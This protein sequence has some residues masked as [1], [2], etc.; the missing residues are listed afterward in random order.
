MKCT[1]AVCTTQSNAYVEHY[2][3]DALVTVYNALG[4]SPESVSGKLTQTMSGM[5][6]KVGNSALGLLGTTSGAQ[7]RSVTDGFKTAN[8]YRIADVYGSPAAA[9]LT[10]LLGQVNTIAACETSITPYKP[11]FVSSTNPLVWNS[12]VIDAISS[13]KTSWG[14]GTIGERS[15]GQSSPDN[16]WGTVN[17]RVGVVLNHDHLKVASVIAYRAMDIVFNGTFGIFNQT[18]GGETLRWYQPSHKI[19]EKSTEEGKWQMLYPRYES[20]CHVLADKSTM[21]PSGLDFE[22]WSDR[23]SNDGSYA[24]HYWRRYECCKRPSGYS[25]LFKTTW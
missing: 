6:G 17:P 21:K 16:S 15:D 4:K 2:S 3:P 8:H 11:Y 1:L 19:S 20:S 25:F 14:G 22:G 10:T 9:A 7:Q 24:W 18:L 5:V 23:R 12:G 13:F